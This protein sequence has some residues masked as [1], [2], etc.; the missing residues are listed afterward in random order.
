[1][2]RIFL[3]LSLLL[4]HLSCQNKTGAYVCTPCDLACD[5]LA[6]NEAGVCPHC[7]MDLVLK[8]SL[9]PEKV[10]TLNEIDIQDGSGKFLIEG[11]FDKER[12]LVVYY[13]KPEQLEPDSPTVIVLPGAGRNG[14]DYRNAWIEK[15]ELYN[16]LVLSPTYAEAYYPEFWSY[17]LAGMIT[18]VE[19]NAVRTAMTSFKIND[20]PKAW[21]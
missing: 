4:A 11:G 1:M 7:T 19:I 5:E 16:V 13:Y 3:L 8:S 20:H 18:D 12:T 9:V 21:I 14:D 15:A 10:L 6:F 17:N 2:T